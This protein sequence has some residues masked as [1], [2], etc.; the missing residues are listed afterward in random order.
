MDQG[1]PTAPGVPPPDDGRRHAEERGAAPTDARRRLPIRHATLPGACG[2]L[3]L[4]CLSFS[5]SLLPRAGILQGVITG[6]LAA[7]GYALG[8]TAAWIWR[9]FTDRE[10]RPARGRSWRVLLVAGVVLFGVAFGLGQ[11]WQHRI[12]LLLGVTEYSLL[13][14]IVMP[15][16]A[17]LFFWIILLAARGVRRVY[18]WVAGL[19]RMYVGERA[20]KAVGGILVAAASVLLLSG[21]LVDGL[22]AAANQAFSLRDT[23]TE[24]GVVRPS[25]ALRSGG[26]GTFVPWDSLG[27][28]GRTFVA[29]GPSAAE[30]ER[31]TRRP[32]QEPVRSYAGLQTAGDTETRAA[33]AVAD[34]RRIGG[35]RRH[36][37]LVM[38]T[39]GSGWVDPAAVDSFEYLT[40]G[41]SAT[42]ALQYSY[43]PSW[44]S[45]LVDQSK[46]REAGRELFD[47]VYDTWSKLPPDARPRLY[48]AGESLGS[49]GGETAFSGE[50]DLR[51]RTSG[52]LFAGPPQFNTLFRRFS[53]HREAGSPEIQPVYENGRTVRF[54]SD[55]AMAVP[56]SDT[57]WEG[58]R[59]LY[60]LH[61]SDPIVWW[62]PHLMYDE[63]DWIG[64]APGHDVLESMFWVPFVTFWQVTADLPFATGVPDGHGH[65]YRA[66]Y[67]DGWNAVLR[68][69]GVGEED[70]H[71]LRTVISQG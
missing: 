19:L 69:S 61:A 38:T 41:D 30:I 39:T 45:Y 67:V 36:N 65:T 32:A 13:Q 25:T 31:F 51:N 6:I 4:G 34:L 10:P 21:L 5:P 58:T 22:V 14:A 47:A 33:R 27:R 70:L 66:E 64:E 48:V 42:V 53:D 62:G 43:L 11:Y 29:G 9:A 71:R 3:L 55:A 52:T 24:E 2:A 57:P 63:P 49:F 18:R 46:A 12:R 15:L 35:F 26:P 60:L 40:G 28:K 68:P 37:L 17:F 56:P 50:Y 1:P 23:Q 20:A 54:A 7:I 59:V 44:M 16:V 8:V